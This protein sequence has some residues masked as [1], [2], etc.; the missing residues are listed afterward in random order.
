MAVCGLN[1]EAAVQYRTFEDM[2]YF[3]LY[4]ILVLYLFLLNIYFMTDCRRHGS[5]LVTLF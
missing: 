4:F 3:I 1:C 5:N 2:L